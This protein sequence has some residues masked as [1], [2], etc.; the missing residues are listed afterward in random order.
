MKKRRDTNKGALVVYDSESKRLSVINDIAFN[1]NN[2]NQRQS[3]SN[4]LITHNN[5]SHEV[6]T[7]DSLYCSKCG[8]PF[9]YGEEGTSKNQDGIRFNHGGND[10]FTTPTF[11]NMNYFRLLD[12][13]LIDGHNGNS[14][15]ISHSA[16]SQ[17][18]F[19]KYDNLCWYYGYTIL[20]IFFR[21]FVTKGLLGRGARGAV[22]QVEHILDGVSLGLF[23]LKKVSIG[24]DHTWLEHV[25]TEVNL[26]RGLS[27]PNLVSYNHVWLENSK[28]STYGPKVPCAFILLEYC[29]GGT[30]EE[31]IFK[32]I[33]K[34]ISIEEKKNEIRRKRR[35]SR[36]NL[37]PLISS[38]SAINNN[39]NNN[40]LTIK[41]IL[42][43]FKDITSGVETLHQNNII[44]RDLKPSNVLLINHYNGDDNN[45]PRV[46][47]SDFGE[48][49]IAGKA[50]SA[51]GATGTLEYC[52]PEVVKK[53]KCFFF[54]FFFSMEIEIL[55]TIM[56]KVDGNLSEFTTKADI[57]SMG[58]ILHFLIFGKL[59]YSIST[60]SITEESINTIGS[61]SGVDFLKLRQEV[62]EFKGFNID[63]NYNNNNSVFIKR[64]DIPISIF[65]LLEKM[66]DPEP[67]RRPDAS[68]ILKLLDHLLDIKVS[69]IV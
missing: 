17:G 56:I 45:I 55:M 40:K 41:E 65:K 27:H 59:P 23:A 25:L 61:G 30:L 46:L 32:R 37:D 39:D 10:G 31:F 4:A 35:Q 8:K 7:V 33:N 69:L 28:V 54:H 34:K 29:S 52:A 44:H 50:R 1:Y 9:I 62:C 53:S 58:M 64:N 42:S 18:Y 60:S 24:D 21:F 68:D 48:G 5:N 13:E 67:E 6:V 14:V 51:T 66:L 38:S 22:Y 43:F 11:I 20:T 19:D 63:S 3:I 15:G 2:N 49:Q 57:F 36:N 16:F 26:F 12:K 47:V